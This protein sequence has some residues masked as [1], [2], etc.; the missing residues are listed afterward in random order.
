MIVAAPSM[1][2]ATILAI[3]LKTSSIRQVWSPSQPEGQGKKIRVDVIVGGMVITHFGVD[4]GVLCAETK[5]QAATEV[6]AE[7]IAA[8]GSQHGICREE[9]AHATPPPDPKG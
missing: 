4:L 7:C 5:G 3:A 1:P 2:S 6:A 9:S 8:G